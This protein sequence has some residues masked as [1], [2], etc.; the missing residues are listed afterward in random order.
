MLIVFSAF[1]A[2]FNALIGSAPRPVKDL[3]CQGRRKSDGRSI[4]IWHP[5]GRVPETQYIYRGGILKNLVNDAVRSM[6]DLTHGGLVEFGDYSASLRKRRDG[7][8]FVNQ[9]VA[10]RSG[11]VGTIPID[12]ADDNLQIIPGL[13]CQDYR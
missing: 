3:D 12:A 2:M 11:S 1:L 5:S 6:Y 4:K 13:L 10:K 7:K 8:R 9:E